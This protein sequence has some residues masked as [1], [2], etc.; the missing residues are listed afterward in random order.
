MMK[1]KKTI[2]TTG[3]VIALARGLRRGRI[4]SLFT[5]E[6]L[7]GSVVAD[8]FIAFLLMVFV[9]TLTRPVLPNDPRWKV[10]VGG[11]GSIRSAFTRATDDPWRERL[12][13]QK[14]TNRETK[15]AG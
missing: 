14:P 3:L 5:G 4:V 15:R 6:Y 1:S 7:D 13:Q 2:V 9:P 10:E 8:L 11:L 12:L